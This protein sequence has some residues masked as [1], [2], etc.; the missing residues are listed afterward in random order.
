VG[1]VWKSGRFRNFQRPWRKIICRNDELKRGAVKFPQ[2]AIASVY[3][4]SLQC[5]RAAERRD[6]QGTKKVK[7]IFD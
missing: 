6:F 7:T 3:A 4:A 2:C 1:N 5:W